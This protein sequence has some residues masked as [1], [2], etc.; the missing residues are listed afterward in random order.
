[1]GGG[2]ESG[3]FTAGSPDYSAGLIREASF[4]NPGQINYGLVFGVIGVA[5]CSVVFVSLWT[6]AA[7]SERYRKYRIREPV[8]DPL[9]KVSK[10]KQVSNAV[11]FDIALCC[12]YLVLAYD[13]LVQDGSVGLLTMFGQILAILLIYDF[14]FYWVHRLFHHPFLMRHVHGVHHKVRFPKAVDDFYIH[15]VDSFWVITLFFS[16][17]AIVG[18][19]STTSMI[20]TLFVWVFINNSLHSGLNFP[21]PLFTLTN[22][23][24]R[25]H[26]VHHGLNVSANFGSIFPFWDMMF[27]THVP[28]SDADG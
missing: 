27:G 1:M 28:I 8:R 14:M 15:P 6:W 3:F 17:I 9:A 19:L 21:H 5:I 18:P 4:S 22:Y 12:A 23:W 7:G 2:Q 13:W 10:F 24:A 26:E 11:V 25:R 20:V 16:S